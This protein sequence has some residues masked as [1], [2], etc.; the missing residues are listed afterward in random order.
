MPIFSSPGPRDVPMIA[1]ASLA[2]LLAGAELPAGAAPELHRLAQA[3]AELNGQPA[4][5]EL[6][7]EAETMAAFRQW[8]GAEGIAPR[9]QA[10]NPRRLRPRRAW[11]AA[12][13]AAVLG[14]TGIATAAYAG[15]LPAGMQRVA[16]AVIGA[17]DPDGRPSARSTKVPPGQVGH[18]LCTAWANAREH[19]A[20]RLQAAA[21]RKL[22]KAAGGAGKVTAFC[23]KAGPPGTSSSHAPHS[24]S[25]RRGSGKPSGLPTPHG[26]G[27]PSGLPTP[28]GSGKPTDLPAARP[29]GQS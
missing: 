29:A 21:F 5:D 28:H 27:K 8:F 20:R 10:R 26:S 16:H 13:A 7:G 15:D 17:P 22:T 25:T 14:F 19:G 11:A 23:L 9:P 12:A 2:A 3:L 24:A 18:G 6:A 1:D 4:G